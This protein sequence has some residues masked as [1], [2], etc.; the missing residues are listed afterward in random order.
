MDIPE[1][2]VLDVS[3]LHIGESIHVK[4]VKVDKAVIKESPDVV[5]AVV[6]HPTKEEAPVVAAAVEGVE[7]AVPVEGAAPAE[8]AAAPAVDGKD[9]A[10]KDAKPGAAKDGKAPA[11][12]RDAAGKDA[13]AGPAKDAKAAPAGKESRKPGGDKK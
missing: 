2:I 9:A 7:G 11:P 6:T 12:G 10:G 5:L 4:D 3:E 8:G 13:K 1:K